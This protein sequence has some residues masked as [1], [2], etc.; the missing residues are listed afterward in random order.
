LKI[1]FVVNPSSG[2][3]NKKKIIEEIKVFCSQSRHQTELWFWEPAEALEIKLRQALDEGVEIV[4]AVGG[5][6]T[7]HHIASYLYYTPVALAIIPGGTGN[8]IAWHLGI[9]RNPSKALA[10]L[11]NPVFEVIDTG[12]VDGKPFV[13]FTGFGVDAQVAHSFVGVKKR[14]L[15]RYIWL[16]IW[17]YFRTPHENYELYLDCSTEPLRKKYEVLAICNTKIFGRGAVV[18]PLASVT[19]NQLDVCGLK[20]VMPWHLPVIAW[21]VFGGTIHK[22]SRYETVRAATVKV[23]RSNPDRSQIDGE[24]SN[25]GV[26]F[27]VQVVPKSLKVVVNPHAVI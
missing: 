20:P 22:F 14:S 23:K 5:D 8:G 9:S 11:D 12:M 4:A 24:A 10:L 7:I 19:D 15:Y 25:A 27:E 3:P 16:S 26:I 2:S 18:A 13:G 6:G 21:R 1:L 17:H